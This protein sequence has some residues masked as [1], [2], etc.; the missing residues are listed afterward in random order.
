MLKG[1]HIEYLEQFDLPLS[2][3]S[4]NSENNTTFSDPIFED[5]EY[6][7]LF[8]NPAKDYAIVYYE[9]PG[10]EISNSLLMVTDPHGKLLSAIPL[11]NSK[12]QITLNLKGIANG[13]YFLSLVQ[14]R[15]IIETKK[16]II[17]R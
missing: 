5:K 13:N 10:K 6:L 1:G 9:V 16:M 11:E 8:P 12:N 17:G 15:R 2:Y 3:K 7:W 4:G 14:D